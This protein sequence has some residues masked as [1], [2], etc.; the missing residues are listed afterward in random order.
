MRVLNLKKDYALWKQVVQNNSFPVYHMLDGDASRLSWTGNRDFL[1]SV[2]VTEDDFADYTTEF[3]SGATVVASEDEVIA[4]AVGLAVVPKLTASDGTPLSAPRTLVLGNNHFGRTDDGSQ[5]MA[6][7]GTPGG[8]MLSLWDGTGAGDTG[9]D[10]THSEAGNETAAAAH[11]GTNGLNTTAQSGGTFTRFNNGSLLDVVGTYDSIS[12]WL[13][14]K[15]YPGNATLRIGFEDAANAQVGNSVNVENYVTNMDPDVWQ[16]VEIPVADFGLTA[17]VQFLALRY[18]GTGNQRHFV[19]EIELHQSGGAG[20]HTFQVVAPVGESWHVTMVVVVLVAPDTGWTSVNFADLTS[21]T[22]GLLIRHRRI[23][24][25]EVLWA[26]NSK[27]NIDLFGRY[28]P[29]ESFNFDNGEL[30]VGFMIKP[31]QA[32]DVVVTDDEVLEY[33]VRDD[34]SPLINVRAFAHYGVEIKV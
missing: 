5:Q 3:E 12:F 34:L 17:D 23:S 6:L 24:D 15:A 8:A 1:Y 32:A 22:N 13:Q 28:H 9:A 14:P 21:L 25:G 30:L 16:R 33:V 31:G 10:W 26:L 29:Q 20:P 19:D 7:D 11:S 4:R 27:D 18:N 2:T